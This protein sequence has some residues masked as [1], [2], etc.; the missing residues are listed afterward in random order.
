MDTYFQIV[1]KLPIE[2]RQSVLQPLYKEQK[3]LQFY[4]DKCKRLTS[5]GDTTYTLIKDKNR[6]KKYEKILREIGRHR[7]LEAGHKK[8]HK[9]QDS[10]DTQRYH[11]LILKQVEVVVH[12]KA[13]YRIQYT[14]AQRMK[15]KTKEEGE[16]F[17]ILQEDKP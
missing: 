15:A 2:V 14:E 1:Q 12:M 5:T 7:N 10:A 13:C 8:L 6:L 11:D 4:L 3:L 9:N 17:Y 16:P